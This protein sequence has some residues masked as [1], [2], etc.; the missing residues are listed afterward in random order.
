MGEGRLSAPCESRGFGIR[1]GEWGPETR[2]GEGCRRGELDRPGSTRLLRLRS[3]LLSEEGEPVRMALAKADDDGM[4]LSLLSPASI[5]ASERPRRVG[6]EVPNRPAAL[7]CDRGVGHSKGLLDPVDIATDDDLFSPCARSA[8]SG[9]LRIDIVS[10]DA[11]GL[12]GVGAAGS[13][14][15][16]S[17]S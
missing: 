6:C 15:D 14:C 11:T 2:A 5:S 17:G 3:K 9:E 12:R 1:S 4:L 10:A 16:A 7:L 8:R 13:D